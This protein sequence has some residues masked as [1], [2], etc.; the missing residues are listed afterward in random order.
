MMDHRG[1]GPED[2]LAIDAYLVVGAGQQGRSHVEA[3]GL[4]IELLAAPGWRRT[5]AAAVSTGLPIPAMASAL[6]YFDGYCSART[7]ANL[8]QALRD[9]FGAHTYER[10]D[11]PGS[12]HT[13]WLEP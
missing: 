11:R 8:I 3:L 2:L 5:V 4:A 12:F 13:N 6:A 9:C 10:L 1:D 7:S